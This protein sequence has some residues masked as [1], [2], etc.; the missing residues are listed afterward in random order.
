[1]VDAGEVTL[2]ET[3]DDDPAPQEPRDRRLV[4]IGFGADLLAIALCAW[5]A[6][7]LSRGMDVNFDQLNY[8]YYY[9]W[10]LFHGGP[11][12]VDPEPFTNRYVNPLPQLPWFFFDSVLSP[13]ASAGAIAALAG[14]NLGLVR[15]ITMVVLEGSVRPAGRLALGIAAMAV[16]GVAA[17]FRLSLGTSLSDVI[18]AIPVLGSLLALLVGARATVGVR[19]R[20]WW[21]VLAGLLAG[22]AVGAKLTMGPFVLALAVATGVLAWTLRS[23]RPVLGLALGG[24]AGVAASGGWWFLSVYHVTGNPMFPYYNNIFGSDL[25]PHEAFR[26]ETYG[27]TSALDAAKYPFYMFDGTDRLLEYRLRDPRWVLLEALVLAAAVLALVLL[28]RRGRAAVRPPL[29]GVLVGVFF[30]VAALAWLA[31]FGIARYAVPAELLTGTL[32]VILLVFLVR[33]PLPAAAVAVAVAL[34][35]AP[36]VQ[37]HSAHREFKP[38]RYGVHAAALRAIPAGS[39]VLVDGLSAPSGFLLSYVPD[40]SRRH[41]VHPWFYGSPLLEKLKREQIATAPRIYVIKA[42]WWRSQ[43]SAKVRFEQAVGVRV[44]PET[45]QRIRNN[46]GPR[47]L[48][49]A[50]WVG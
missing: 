25:W 20:F 31:Q 46:V 18:L 32:I 17:V 29:A 28:R 43:T 8:H 9:S 22:A 23:T 16:A 40:T 10:L 45:C 36:F 48:C 14:V 41:L 6:T 35:M 4:L 5:Y 33:R 39:V 2:H 19:G 50:V 44:E 37:G 49:R 13:R 30:V 7:R 21:P 11:H 24:I 15:R 47:E 42:G 34:V 26:D 27:P 1:M 12:Q 38:D 3:R